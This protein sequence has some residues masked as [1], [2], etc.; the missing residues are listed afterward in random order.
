M[1]LPSCKRGGSLGMVWQE[2]TKGWQTE[3]QWCLFLDFLATLLLASN[4]ALEFM[5]MSTLVSSNSLIFLSFFFFSSSSLYTLSGRKHSLGVCCPR[6]SKKRD[7]GG[8]GRKRGRRKGEKD[9]RGVFFLLLLTLYWLFVSFF[10]FLFFS[11]ALSSLLFWLASRV[12]IPPS[13]RG[14]RVRGVERKGGGGKVEEEGG[15]K[16][17]GM[18]RGMKGVIKGGDFL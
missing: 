3:N 4:F 11:F 16:K 5:V 14:W 2:G 6:R 17:G 7:G 12:W 10:D 8:R 1:S 9:K 18:A 15:G 13:K